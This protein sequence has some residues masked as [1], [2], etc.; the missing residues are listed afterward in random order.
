MTNRA[1]L[2]MILAGLTCTSLAIA[3]CSSSSTTTPTADTSSAD[4]SGADTVTGTTAD[5][6]TQNVP[7]GDASDSSGGDPYADISA[8]P[9]TLLTDGNYFL[10]VFAKV[11]NL[12][13]TF[14]VHIKAEGTPTAGGKIKVFELRPLGPDGIAGDIMTVA[15]DIPVDATGTFAIN[16]PKVVLP[17]AYS[18]TGTDVPIILS[19]SGKVHD[20]SM[21][22]GDVTGQVPAFNADLAGSTFKGVTLGTQKSPDPDAAC[23]TAAAK[24][25]TPIAQCPAIAAGNNTLK[26]AERN[27]D[28]QVYLPASGTPTEAVPLVVLYHGVGGSPGGIITDTAYDKL[29]GTNNFI[30]VA[31]KSDRDGSGNPVLQTEWYYGSPLFDLDNPDLVY[32]DDLV[33]C[34]S[35]S[36]KIDANRIY[37]TG[38]SGG[39]LMSTFL[40]L[41]RSKTI[42][43]AA[44]FSGGYLQTLPWAGDEKATPFMVV[45]GGA[46]D[47]AFSQNFDTLAKALIAKLLTDKHYVIGCNHGTGHKWPLELTAPN[48]AFLSNFKLGDTTTAVD[49]VKN[50][51]SYCTLQK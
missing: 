7:L 33:K 9:N 25:Y 1:L 32:F 18:P 38:M 30:L 45:W 16:L 11:F 37:V 48:W 46:S 3:G 8:G 24:V 4:V 20:A 27:R 21:F 36:Y 39:G 19:L 15:Y 12:K 43:A 34:L 6:D 31:P 10:A 22:C 47:S 14:Q 26:S 5:A 42:A 41:H 51:P 29:L 28:F 23:E 35:A 17:G 44:P 40:G 49:L 13:L 50:M 2:R